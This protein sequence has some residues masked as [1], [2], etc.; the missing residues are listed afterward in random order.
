MAEA[1][2][3]HVRVGRE[4]V[5]ASDAAALD[6]AIARSNAALR[7]ADLPDALNPAI[8]DPAKAHALLAALAALPA[9]ALAPLAGRSLY[10]NGPDLPVRTTSPA[11]PA[12]FSRLTGL[13]APDVQGDT[14]LV[15]LVMPLDCAL[16]RRQAD[17]ARTAM[18]QAGAVVALLEARQ[19]S[20]SG[21]DQG[22]VL[23]DLAAARTR[24]AAIAGAWREN[25]AAASAC[26]PDDAAA[27]ADLAEAEQAAASSAVPA[28]GGLE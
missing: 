6:A 8:I 27:S 20:E 15:G 25:A 4:T 26:A 11:T 19:Q 3:L 1:A 21:A 28:G 7:I 14:V 5:A 23:P 16:A 12:G 10:L 13:A 17:V 2:P 24:R 9:D 22:S 18:A